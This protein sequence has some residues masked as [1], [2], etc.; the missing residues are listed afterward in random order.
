MRL[1]FNWKLKTVFMQLWA[2]GCVLSFEQACSLRAVSCRLQNLV[3]LERVEMLTIKAMALA[4][5]LTFSLNGAASCDAQKRGNAPNTN[6]TGKAGAVSNARPEMP[7]KTAPKGELKILA[8]GQHSTVSNAFIVVAREAATYGALRKLVSTLPEQDEN[9]FRSNLVVAAF[10]GERRSGGYSVR[11]MENGNKTLRVEETTPPKGSMTIQ[12]MTY[13]FAVVAVPVSNQESLALDMGR[14]WRSA[15]RTYRIKDGDFTMSGGIAGRS[16]KFGIVGSLDI[17]R[18]T[19]LATFFFN[20]QS[21]DK[22]KPRAL[23]DIATGIVQA[24]GK[25][26]IARMV[27]G[28]FVG[29]PA[30]ALRAT[31]LFGDKEN[32]LS[33]SFGSIPGRIADGFNGRGTLNAEATSQ[34]PGRNGAAAEDAPQ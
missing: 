15:A 25:I 29:Q 6:Q 18:E 12:V 17:L 3:E 31:G 20:L 34:A 4:L 10:L 2:G 19:G 27:A 26:T 22:A 14:N 32:K 1:P 9:F 8:E 30:D 13:P 28:S 16:E 23:K 24:D 21:S 33:L 7:D 11:F 5:L